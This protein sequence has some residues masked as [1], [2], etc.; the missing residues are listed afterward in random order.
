M[1]MLAIVTFVRTNV[2]LDDRLIK[3]VMNRYGFRTKRETI[4]YAL[5]RLD[6][7]KDP[8]TGML[9]LEGSGWEGDLAEMRRTRF[10]E[11]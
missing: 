3:R 2:V 9:E 6:G 8:W 1:C 10:P 4:D 7:A 11:I 5:R